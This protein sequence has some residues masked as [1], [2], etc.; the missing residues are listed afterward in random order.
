MNLIIKLLAD[1]KKSITQQ[2]N[3]KN[4]SPILSQEFHLEFPS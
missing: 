1:F 2:R 3:Q 4:T